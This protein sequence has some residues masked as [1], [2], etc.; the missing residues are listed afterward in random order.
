M[1]SAW[2]E[3]GL[4]EAPA[5][6]Q[7]AEESVQ[8]ESEYFKRIRIGRNCN[9]SNFGFHLKEKKEEYQGKH[10]AFPQEGSVMVKERQAHAMTEGSGKR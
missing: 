9:L 8:G 1:V 5:G 2:R 4:G 3:E 10:R 6:E 7:G